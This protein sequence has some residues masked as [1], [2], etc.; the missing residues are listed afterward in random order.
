[1]KY[2]LGTLLKTMVEQGASDL[3]RINGQIVRAKTPP[4]APE[5]TRGICYALIT[6]TQKKKFEVEH[7]LDFAFGFKNM[8]RLR[9]NFFVQRGSVAAVFRRIEN[10]IRPLDQLGLSRHVQGLVDRPSGL[11][12]VTGATGSGKSTTLAAMID[13]INRTQRYHIVTIEDPIEYTHRHQTSIVNQ[14]EIGTDCRSFSTALRAV[15]REDPDVIMVGE[16]RDAETAEAALKAAET[17]HLVF[18]TLHTNGAIATINRILQIFPLDAQDYVRSLL[19]FTLEGIITQALVPR[20]DKRGRILVYEYMT[21]TPAIRTLIRENKLH[22]AY[23]QMQIGQEVHGMTT[24]N[25]ALSQHVLAGTITPTEALAHSPDPE[26]LA[27]M[28][29]KGGRKVV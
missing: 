11:V 7:E 13:R 8:A 14:R 5:D 6:E 12:L 10:E 2:E 1:V 16:I 15:L 17:G 3:H 28:I 22:Q 21:T 24:L 4:L 9:A 18:S 25:Q 23:G 20:A 27:R 29:E 19:A 26:E